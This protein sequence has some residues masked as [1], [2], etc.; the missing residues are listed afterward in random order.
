LFLFFISSKKKKKKKSL[1]LSCVEPSDALAARGDDAHQMLA[2]MHTDEEC[3]HLD[4][5]CVTNRTKLR[6]RYQHAINRIQGR[7]PSFQ[8]FG[9]KHPMIGTFRGS[10]NKKVGK[11][12]HEHMLQINQDHTW[13]F[14]DKVVQH[15]DP[16][17]EIMAERTGFWKEDMESDYIGHFAEVKEVV[18]R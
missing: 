18:T 12:D 13:T 17:V 15:D 16:D 1:A 8:F 2:S 9:I 7:D 5:T 4:Q 3:H 10:A 6:L 11:Q 14:R